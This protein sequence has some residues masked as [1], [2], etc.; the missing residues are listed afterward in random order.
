L[1]KKNIKTKRL[2][3][4]LDYKKLKLFKIN[5]KIGFINYKF[6]LLKIIKIYLVF[7]ILFFKPVPL[8]T[9]AILIIKV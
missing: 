7:Y 4:K 5:K 8:N 6:K 1:F 9:F 2:N 3:N